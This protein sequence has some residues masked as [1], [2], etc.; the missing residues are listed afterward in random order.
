MLS[1]L[2]RSNSRQITGVEPPPFPATHY[3]DNRI[4]TD[5][6]V[7]AAESERIFATTWKFVLHESEIAQEGDFRT[8]TVAGR[9]LIVIRGDD[10]R[11]RTFLNVC[12]HRGAQIVRKPAGR[13]ANHKVQCFY[14]LWTFNSRGRCTSIAQSKGYEACGLAAEDVALR[15]VRTE[16]LFGLVFVCLDDAAE[17]LESFLGTEIVEALRVPFGSA[18]LEVFHL[19]RT[20]LKSNWKQFVE[21]NCEGYH[22][23]LHRL[24]RK[25]G[26]AHKAYRSRQWHL[27]GNGHLVFEQAAIGYSSL[28]LEMRDTN[29]LPG[30][31]PNGHVV[32]DLFPDVMLNCRSTVVRIDSLTP[33]APGL[34]RLECRGLGVKGD[35]AEQRAQRIS[36]HNQVWGP[37]G[38]NLPED[39]WAVECQWENISTGGSRYSVIAREEGR[40]PMDDATMRSFYAEW[41]KRVRYHSHDIDAPWAS[42]AG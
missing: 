32:V 41:R 6:G 1:I 11:V 19:H 26:V 29:L 37:M 18:E 35:T 10:G 22:E 16:S 15:E 31:I 12:P 38:R 9:P 30:M 4:Y 28:D 13:L 33:I 36:Q 34:T 40:G 42:N 17:S 14:H 39:I 7:F 5:P 23:L 27:H 3:V 24:N 20:E 21:T 25:T 8:A 2:Q